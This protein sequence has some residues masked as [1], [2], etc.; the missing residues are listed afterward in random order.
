MS[1]SKDII[2]LTF[3]GE[4]VAK[5]L[6]G[7]NESHPIMIE[8]EENSTLSDDEIEIIPDNLKSKFLNEAIAS[9]KNKCKQYIKQRKAE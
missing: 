6:K 2:D 7:N 4:D 1:E 3:I 8:S 5:T 9:Y